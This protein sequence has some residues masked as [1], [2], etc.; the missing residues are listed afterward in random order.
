MYNIRLFV[1]QF[2][3][4]CVVFKPNCL[5]LSSE[6]FRMIC[7]VKD[8]EIRMMNWYMVLLFSFRDNNKKE[9]KYQSKTKLGQM[10]KWTGIMNKF[11][12]G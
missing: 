12:I 8:R 9:K 11:A 7:Y 10:S 4:F 1:P 5:P 2:R 3:F 6:I